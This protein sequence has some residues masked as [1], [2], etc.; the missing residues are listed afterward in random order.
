MY[1]Y[2]YINIY[3]S[4]YSD[5]CPTSQPMSNKNHLK[6]CF[7]LG[8]SLIE[9][10]IFLQKLIFKV[11]SKNTNTFSQFKYLCKGKNMKQ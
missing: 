4:F 6:K 2:M 8:Q 9:M 5:P 11:N 10:H 1:L 3:T 7:V